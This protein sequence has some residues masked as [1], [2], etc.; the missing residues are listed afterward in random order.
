[1]GA[2]VAAVLLY[3]V[4]RVIQSRLFPDADPAT[5]IFSPHAGFYWRC[6]T[7]GYAGL[8][9]GFL[10]YGGAKANLGATLRALNV[11]VVTSAALLAFQGI[12]VP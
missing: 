6:W 1:M 10:A 5:V 9:A 3:A 4:L 11:G 12:F 7:V 2:C 8:M